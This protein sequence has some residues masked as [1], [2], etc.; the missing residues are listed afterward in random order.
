MLIKNIEQKIGKNVVTKENALDFTD[1][2]EEYNK[3]YFKKYK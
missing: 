1:R 3:K 2:K